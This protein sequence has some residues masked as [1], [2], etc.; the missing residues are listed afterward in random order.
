M[1]AFSAV[2]YFYNKKTIRASTDSSICFT[3]GSRNPNTNKPGGAE[4]AVR[5]MW[6]IRLIE[7]NATLSHQHLPPR[8][9]AINSCSITGTLKNK[10]AL[11]HQIHCAQHA[12]E[13]TDRYSRFTLFTYGGFFL[14]MDAIATTTFEIKPLMY[15]LLYQQFNLSIYIV[16]QSIMYIVVGKVTAR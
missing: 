9:I 3:D 11:R 2:V 6:L 13:N 14:R 15:Y 7:I 4:R 5:E 8:S 1:A 10:P 16:T 12:A